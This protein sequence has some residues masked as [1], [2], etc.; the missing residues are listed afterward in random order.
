MFK[1]KWQKKYEEDMKLIRFRI[2][3]WIE[4]SEE[5]I[6]RCSKDLANCTNPFHM[7]FLE[8]NKTRSEGILSAMKRM[9]K[10]FNAIVLSK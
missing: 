8:K 2:E 3:A 9:Q 7:K 10:D 4:S 1:T 5:I 6:E